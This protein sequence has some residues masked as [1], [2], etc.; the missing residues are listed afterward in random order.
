MKKATPVLLSIVCVAA[1]ATGI[2][3]VEATS[4]WTKAGNNEQS[5]FSDK[6]ARN[7][8]DI[9][10]IVVQENTTTTQNA[11][12]LTR[13]Q[14]QGGAGIGIALNSFLNQFLQAAPKWFGMATGIPV[15]D[16]D[17]TIPTLDFAAT[18]EWNAGGRA[19]NSLT[20]SNRTAVTVVDVLPNGN[21][22]VEGAKIIRTN[23]EDQ[24]AYMRGVVRPV[25][26][27]ADNTVPSTKIADAQV[28][29]IPA[30]QLTEAQKKGWLLR[31][32][33]KV[34]PF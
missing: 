28:E 17:V 18:G 26:I 22:V 30:G 32:W 20:V 2:P 16:D 24:Y 3:Q 10:T 21:L 7:I 23:Q 5:M 19:A 12:L 11:D 29:F 9:V 31:A 1:I 33:E 15:K 6:I 25:D 34:K 27:E 14:Y 4:L 8:G 13:D